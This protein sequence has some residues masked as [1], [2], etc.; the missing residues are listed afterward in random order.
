V[1]YNP[2]TKPLVDHLT[3]EPRG[4]SIASKSDLLPTELA[5]TLHPSSEHS[6]ITADN[7]A[8]ASVRPPSVDSNLS[9]WT[10]CDAEEFSSMAVCFALSSI[11]ASVHDGVLCARPARFICARPCEEYVALPHACSSVYAHS[12]HNAA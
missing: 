8:M 4:S 3:R 9:D 10:D 12:Q 2:F 6:R 5:H 11:V 1:C 7:A